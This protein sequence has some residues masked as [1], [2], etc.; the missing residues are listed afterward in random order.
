VIV[1]GVGALV[2]APLIEQDVDA[3]RALGDPVVHLV[4]SVVDDTV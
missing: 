4:R 2:T 1:A 3:I